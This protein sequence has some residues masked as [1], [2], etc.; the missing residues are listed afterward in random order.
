MMAPIQIRRADPS[1]SI[2]LED[3][4]L[5]ARR[6]A[7]YW[8]A[9]DTFQRSDFATQ[10][11]GEI[12][13]VAVDAGG[14]LLGFISVWL[15]ENFV[16]HLY[17]MPDKKNRG[18]G[19][20]LLGSIA[21]WLPLPHRLKCLAQNHPAIHFYRKHGWKELERGSDALGDYLLME[22]S[23]PHAEMTAPNPTPADPP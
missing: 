20:A 4:F 11:E 3:L 22:Y 23:G 15:P 5:D 8:C 10:T 18:I 1:D 2:A 9:P 16:H 14:N 7:F 12:I 6:K 13:H 21:S 19:T 17:V